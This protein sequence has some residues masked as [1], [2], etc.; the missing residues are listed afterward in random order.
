MVELIDRGRRERSPRNR[1]VWQKLAFIF[2]WSAFVL[3]TSRPAVA[4]VPAQYVAKLYTEALGRA[5]DKSGWATRTS[6][7]SSHV[8]SVTTLADQAREIL[9]SSE[10]RSH[11]YSSPAK[12]L[13]LYRTTLDREPDRGGFDLYLS[14]LNAG[15]SYDD[16]VNVVLHSKEFERLAAVICSGSPYYFN[17]L[18]SG[19]FAI[20]IPGVTAVSQAELQ[21]RLN[22][23]PAGG[24]VALPS[25]TVVALHG[26]LTIPPGVTLTTVGAPQPTSHGAMARIV[27]GA[28]YAG[29]EALIK[30][31]AGGAHLSNIWVDGQRGASA[32]AR[33]PQPFKH[34][35]INIQSLSGEDNAITHN[36][37]ANTAGWSSLQ[38]FGK[39]ET[40]VTCKSNMIAD[41]LITVYASNNSDT[42]DKSWS[43]GISDACEDSI[44]AR[45]AV[46]DAT[47]A[48]IVLFRAQ[49]GSKGAEQHS[50]VID[51]VVLNA[52]N[53]AFVAFGVDP[54]YVS[55]GCPISPSFR[56]TYVG[57]NVFWTGPTAVV[58]IGFAV[59]TSEWFFGKGGCIGAGARVA[60]N[61]TD[62]FK[63]RVNDGI[64]VEGM[65]ATYVQ[66]NTL[67]IAHVKKGRCQSYDT[68]AGV[69]AG[70][71]SG[72]IQRY[73]DDVLKDCI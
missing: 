18:G 64:A 57:R 3:G 1:T 39:A 12:L 46:V 60:N 23:A 69:T 4:A 14:Q 40:G 56:G 42:V 19:G 61:S 43:D 26:T 22:A 20:T 38:V 5:P 68:V 63:A 51:N 73:T 2:A 55:G 50:Q 10:F 17:V 33:T 27:R 36:F 28:D 32:A 53:S 49:V 41:N 58:E 66:A 6:Y 8:C 59:G 48:G 65:K 24:T 71:A 72:S 52:G 54:L 47:D 62:G 67:L 45:N 15:K 9:G 11:N 44:V 70:V 29:G 37:V 21:S 25:M 34:G 30:L 31:M 35:E 16:I 7:F 13:I